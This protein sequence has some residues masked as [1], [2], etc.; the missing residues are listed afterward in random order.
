M[1]VFV[2]SLVVAASL[3]G[4]GRALERADPLVPLVVV[5]P[6]GADAAATD[7][8]VEEAVLVQAAR[9][10]GWDRTDPVVHGRLV[11]VMSDVDPALLT[12]EAKLEAARALGLDL[13]DAVVRVRLADRM[14]QALLASDEPTDAELAAHLDAHPERFEREGIVRFAHVVLRREDRDPSAHQARVDGVAAQLAGAGPEAGEG[15][16]DTLLGLRAL[17]ARTPSTAGRT[18]GEAL[19]E[20]LRSG[21]P[22][23]WL[24]PVPSAYGAHFLYVRERSPDEVPP[25]HAIRA[26]VAADFAR[27]HGPARAAEALEAMKARFD[28]RV[29]PR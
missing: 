7:L 5:V 21:E 6:E 25:L 23:G 12:D 10:Y 26:E 4:G 28:I 16:G 18:W 2:C 24:G 13:V 3:L 14:R 17:D 9:A 29:E 8:A 1:R 11:S 15:L 22:G 27:T 20:A 19:E